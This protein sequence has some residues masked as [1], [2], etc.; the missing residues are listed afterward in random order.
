VKGGPFPVGD[1]WEDTRPF[2]DTSGY[3][4]RASVRATGQGNAA[5][6][7][8]ALRQI[9]ENHAE[10]EALDVRFALSGEWERAALVRALRWMAGLLESDGQAPKDG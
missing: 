8:I 4:V 2:D 6:T 7:V 9:G 5:Q 1:G 3:G 10:G